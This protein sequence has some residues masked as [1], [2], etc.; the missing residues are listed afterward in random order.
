[1]IDISL[2]Y[3]FSWKYF[4]YKLAVHAIILLVRRYVQE[5][6]RDMEFKDSKTPILYYI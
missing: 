6:R 5:N 1:L 2:S 3:F 4:F